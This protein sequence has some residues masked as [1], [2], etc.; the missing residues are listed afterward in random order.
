MNGAVSK[1]YKEDVGSRTSVYVHT[2]HTVTASVIL[3]KKY[4]YTSVPHDEGI[5]YVLIPEGIR[6][7][8]W[9]EGLLKGEKISTGQYI[10]RRLTHMDS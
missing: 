5:K 4:G 9:L 10:N 2:A 1:G 8:N 3:L 7:F 6:D